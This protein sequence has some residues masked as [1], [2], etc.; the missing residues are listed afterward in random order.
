MESPE[1]DNKLPLQIH[2]NSYV[3]QACHWSANGPPLIFK[4][5]L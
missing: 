4:W 2:K 5:Y 1:K 3:S